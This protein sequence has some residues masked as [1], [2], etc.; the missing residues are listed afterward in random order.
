MHNKTKCRNKL[1]NFNGELSNYVRF[2]REVNMQIKKKEPLAR[3][4][5]VVNN[6]TLTTRSKKCACGS[7]EIDRS[8]SHA[9]TYT[10]HNYIQCDVF[11]C[12]DEVHHIILFGG[13]P[14]SG[15]SCLLVSVAT[16][17]IYKYRSTYY[18][19]KIERE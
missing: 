3:L 4:S 15:I 19:F 13:F 12:A 7:Y 1:L 14:N 10:G 9:R 8:Y 11:F 18:T 2:Q 5:L 17:T 6:H 16:V